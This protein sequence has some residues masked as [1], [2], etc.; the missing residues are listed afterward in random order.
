MGKMTRA[1]AA[2]AALSDSF[3]DLAVWASYMYPRHP[4]G[5]LF[6]VM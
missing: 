6:Y 1:R 4:L 5:T 2:R 3:V